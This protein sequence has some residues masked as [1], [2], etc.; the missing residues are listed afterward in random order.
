MLK[1]DVQE[2]MSVRV[3]SERSVDRYIVTRKQGELI[4]KKLV[5]YHPKSDGTE[6]KFELQQESDGS[7]RVIDLLP[8]FLDI[9]ARK[10]KKVFVIDEVDR[11]LH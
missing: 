10:S 5:T 8:A 9:S 11:S 1:E 7:Q 6:T 2:G 4:A 3:I